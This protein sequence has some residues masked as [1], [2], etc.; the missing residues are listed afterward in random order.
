MKY[1]DRCIAVMLNRCDGQGSIPRSSS[2]A[3]QQSLSCSRSVLSYVSHFIST[4]NS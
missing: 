3:S 4:L 2:L 1:S